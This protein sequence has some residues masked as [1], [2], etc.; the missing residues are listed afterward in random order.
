MEYLKNDDIELIKEMNIELE[1][2]ADDISHELEKNEGLGYEIGKY[3]DIPE[4]M[5]MVLIIIHAM[6]DPVAKGRL[7]R[8]AAAYRDGTI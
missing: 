6:L 3:F 4:P 8:I 5:A 2:L 7:E 1:K